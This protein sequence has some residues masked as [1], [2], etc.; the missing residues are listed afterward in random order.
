MDLGPS[1][2]IVR[3]RESPF[4]LASRHSMIEIFF[5]MLMICLFAVEELARVRG[6]YTQRL[7]E[8][9][10]RQQDSLKTC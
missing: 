9:C 7:Q 1:A 6:S 10:L 4:A 8:Y 3:A 2:D 5:T